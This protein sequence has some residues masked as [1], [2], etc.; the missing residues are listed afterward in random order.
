MPYYTTTII[1]HNGSNITNI[2]FRHNLPTYQHKE[3]KASL[4]NFAF[5]HHIPRRVTTFIPTIHHIYHNKVQVL[6]YMQLR[7]PVKFQSQTATHKAQTYSNNTQIHFTYTKFS[8]IYIKHFQKQT[9][10]ESRQLI[11]RD[12]EESINPHS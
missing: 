10:Y 11:T 3:K 6:P 2:I 4:H 7:L 5:I 9:K 1:V 8:H 12:M